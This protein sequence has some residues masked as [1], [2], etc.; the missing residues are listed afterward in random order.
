M[1]LWWGDALEHD[2]SNTTDGCE[3][4]A[5]KDNDGGSRPSQRQ[6]GCHSKLG[7]QGTKAVLMLFL[8]DSTPAR[9]LLKGRLRGSRAYGAQARGRSPCTR[10]PKVQP[11]T[12]TSLL[13]QPS[14]DKHVR[15]LLPYAPPFQRADFH[16][17]VP[18]QR[19]PVFQ[20]QPSFH[21]TPAS[22][23]NTPWVWWGGSRCIELAHA[24][25]SAAPRVAVARE[26]RR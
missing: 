21:Q 15:S 5:A 9:S 20:N 23:N 3:A 24:D 16:R 7:R 10:R 4:G 17:E 19:P 25:D 2:W 6:L 8:N 22:R 11:R 26:L 12:F 1:S 14:I 13:A 18:L